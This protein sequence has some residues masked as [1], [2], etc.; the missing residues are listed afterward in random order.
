LVSLLIPEMQKA[1]DARVIIVGSITGIY[2]YVCMYV[3]V[4]ICILIYE[5]IHNIKLHISYDIKKLK[6]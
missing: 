5:Y 2:V 3:F 1:K 4:Y 6:K